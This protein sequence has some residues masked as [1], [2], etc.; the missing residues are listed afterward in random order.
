MFSRTKCGKKPKTHV[1]RQKK[2]QKPSF[3]PVS[4]SLNFR[5]VKTV[6]VVV[7]APH[8]TPRRRMSGAPSFFFPPFPCTVFSLAEEAKHST[9]CSHRANRTKVQKNFCSSCILRKERFPQRPSAAAL[10]DFWFRDK[11]PPR[12]FHTICHTRNSLVGAEYL[13][14]CNWHNF[15]LAQATHVVSDDSFPASVSVCVLSLSPNRFSTTRKGDFLCRTLGI[16]FA[17]ECVQL[18]FTP[19]HA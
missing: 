4:S 2:P 9:I 11:R 19:T 8:Y 3:A 17:L 14:S 13:N 6:V 5:S 18:F 12:T 15:S 7:V 16:F 10:H 1:S